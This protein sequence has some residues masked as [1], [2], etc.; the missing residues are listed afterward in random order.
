MFTVMVWKS[1]LSCCTDRAFVK[2]R[3]GIRPSHN[4]L[5]TLVGSAGHQARQ[6]ARDQYPQAHGTSLQGVRDRAPHRAANGGV[7]GRCWLAL[8]SR[9]P[10]E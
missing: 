10:L 7:A 4:R 6:K 9:N 3:P 5:G 8:D 1:P 2:K